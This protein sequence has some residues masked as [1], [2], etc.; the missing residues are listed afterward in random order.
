MIHLWEVDGW[1]QVKCYML[2]SITN[3]LQKQYDSMQ[4]ASN[5]LL[6]LRELYWEQSR[7]MR[8]EVTSK[9]F[10]M[11]TVEGSFVNDHV[12]SMINKIEELERLGSNMDDDVKID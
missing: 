4:N 8:F 7:Y 12:L 2:S 10:N 1:Q 11:R 9:I 6:H 5:I 3:E